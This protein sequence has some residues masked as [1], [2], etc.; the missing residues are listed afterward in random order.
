[1]MCHKFSEYM[2]K[3]KKNEQNAKLLNKYKEK[4]LNAEKK[5][6]CNKKNNKNNSMKA[7][8]RKELKKFTP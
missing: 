1:M 8:S 4:Y 3:S 5:Y 2:N 7:C 6:V